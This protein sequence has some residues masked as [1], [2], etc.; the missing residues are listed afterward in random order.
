MAV[1]MIRAL[2]YKPDVQVDV[3]VG[4]L[5]DDFGAYEVLSKVV[6]HKGK[7]FVD[8]ALEYDYDVAVMAIPF[9]GR[10]KNGRD[11]R[12]TAVMDERPRPDPSTMGFSSWKKHEIE[13]QMENARFLGY[14]GNTPS[15]RF[16]DGPRGDEDKIYV[17]LGYKKD[18][19]GFWSVKHWGNENY[20]SLIKIIL[21]RFPE[22]RV[23]TT[24]NSADLACTIGPITRIVNDTRFSFSLPTLD[25]S[26]EIVS[27]CGMYVGNDTGMMHVAAACGNRVVGL[28]FM[29]NANVKNSPWCDLNEVISGVH[30]KIEPSEVVRA[31]EDLFECSSS[32]AG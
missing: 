31:C 1:P 28:F 3:L 17:G 14:L 8:R 4:S 19:A 30:N 11:F 32:Q 18:S 2:Q 15:C 23:V 9:D 20:A 27:S 6:G 24:G 10:W 12:A 25:K 7:I 5:P 21:K 29:E 16:L 26:F 13:Y 22:K